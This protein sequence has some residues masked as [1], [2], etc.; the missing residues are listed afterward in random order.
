MIET[1]VFPCTY[2]CDGK[3]IMCSIH[4]RK[5]S[6]LPIKTFEKFFSSPQ[7]RNIQSINLTG[8]EPT[9]RKDLVQLV[10]M[11]LENCSSLKE[12]IINTNGF[13]SKR[14]LEQ[15]ENLIEI[16]RKDIKVYILIS[17]DAVGKEADYIR[18]VEDAARKVKETIFEL[19]KLRKNFLL[20][21]SCTIIAGNYNLLDDVL[22]YAH[23][24]DLY[25]DFVCATVNSAYINSKPKKDNFTLNDK[26]KKV[27]AQFLD[28]AITYDKLLSS[29][30]FIEK[31]IKRLNGQKVYKECILRK[32]KGILLEADGKI[33]PCG[34]TDKIELGD[35]L[36]TDD[37]SNL[38][39]PLKGYSTFC[40]N[41][42]T[43]SCYNWTSEAQ[44]D[45]LNDMLIS[46]KI[47][48]RKNL[49]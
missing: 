31:T 11:I 32:G 7:I 21:I 27:V 40:E 19:K 12:I 44:E 16:L 3:C 2:H 22:E 4:E 5:G 45:I 35:I 41:C 42:D 9:M 17:M 26:Q 13:N 10:N 34:M 1:V 30:R 18:G 6:D 43:D 38:G 15:I 36:K 48:R 20:G 46:T 14:I 39:Q 25:I 33:R 49:L 47:K 24:E 8:G 37:F 23:K 28:R 29:K